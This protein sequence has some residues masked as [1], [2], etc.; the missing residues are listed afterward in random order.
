MEELGDQQ[1]ML[2]VMQVVQLEPAEE[3]V[4]GELLEELLEAQAVK[5]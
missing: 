5:P 4:V 1:T 2:V 3:A